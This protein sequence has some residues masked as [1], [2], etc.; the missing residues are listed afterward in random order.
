MDDF[1][2]DYLNTVHETTATAVESGIHEMIQNPVSW[3]LNIAVV[4]DPDLLSVMSLGFGMGVMFTSILANP[5]VTK[6]PQLLKK[7]GG[8]YTAAAIQALVHPPKEV[9]KA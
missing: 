7:L 4:K 3:F 9:I 8:E 5:E 6:R 1:L 2:L